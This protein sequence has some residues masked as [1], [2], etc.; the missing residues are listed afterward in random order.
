MP[1]PETAMNKNRGSFRRKNEIR[2][3]RQVGA[4]EPEAQAKRM[5][6]AAHFHLGRRVT[7]LD[8]AHDS[9]AM[10]GREDVSHHEGS[11]A[12]A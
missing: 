4:M 7:R 6:R 8:G 5:S 11:V 1:V 3:S 2:L 12:S 9:R 10:L